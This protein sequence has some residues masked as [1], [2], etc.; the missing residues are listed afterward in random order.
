MTN[1]TMN[2]TSLSKSQIAKAWAVLFHFRSK[3]TD[4]HIYEEFN[5]IITRNMH[6]KVKGH[7]TYHKFH[8]E[9]QKQAVSKDMILRDQQKCPKTG[10]PI[11][12]QVV[13]M[14]N[15]GEKETVFVNF[16]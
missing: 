4:S 8:Q 12:L 7:F 15:Q 11:D 9:M 1:I 16:I 10:W 2:Q 13:S 6:A 5:T 14:K 3:E